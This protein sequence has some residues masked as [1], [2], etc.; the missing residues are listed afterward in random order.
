[1]AGTVMHL[2]VAD[3]LLDIL[4]VNNPAYFY[5]G[6]LAPDAIMARKNYTREMKR[7]T[8]FKDDIHLYEFRQPEKLSVYMDR[9]MAFFHSYVEPERKH[10]EIYLG[11]LTHMLV[12]ELYLLHF[13]DGFVDKLLD[14]GKAPTDAE[15]WDLFTEDVNLVDW[16]LVRSYKFKYKMPDIL[17][18]DE[19]YE[20]EDFITG[21]ELL[22]SKAF[23]I[24]KNFTTK[25]EAEPL[26]VMTMESNLEFIELCIREI[27][28]ILMDRFAL[29]CLIDGDLK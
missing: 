12:D 10:R 15:F 27:P 23:I 22:D 4:K 19:P 7:H 28:R 6:N 9:L 18:L 24:N 1:M 29:N 26:K 21:E 3:R 16:E 2:V 11:Y 17:M 5:C 25:H 20:I 13:R 14:D 8:H